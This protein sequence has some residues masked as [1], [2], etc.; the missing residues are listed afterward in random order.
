MNRD[1]LSG[2][3]G[4]IVLR[5][6]LADTAAGQV[7]VPACL[8]AIGSPRLYRAWLLN[9]ETQGRLIP[10]PELRLYSL[11]RQEGGDAYSRYNSLLR[12][13]ISFEQALDRRLA[14][15]EF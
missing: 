3:P 14:K 7:T 11:L 5:Q 8:A 4:E 9:R 12:E 6:G 2:L 13:L 15:G 10:E 1:L